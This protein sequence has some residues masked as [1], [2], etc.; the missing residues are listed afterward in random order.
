MPKLS[1]NE[2]KLE[3]LN[4]LLDLIGFEGEEYSSVIKKAKTVEELDQI[5]NLIITKQKNSQF[6]KQIVMFWRKIR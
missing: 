6:E 2:L 1:I 3:L 5:L 4:T